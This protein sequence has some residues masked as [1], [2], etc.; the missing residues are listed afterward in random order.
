MARL[1]EFVAPGGTLLVICR[2]REASQP[3]DGPPWPLVREELDALVAAGLRVASFDDVAD[4]DDPSIRR[5]V[6]AFSRP[7]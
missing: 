4:P 6:A 2:A 5:F 1:A 7:N 3:A